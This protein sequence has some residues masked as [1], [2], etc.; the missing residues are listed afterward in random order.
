MTAPAMVVLS[1]M[2]RPVEPCVSA[3]ELD[4][5]EEITEFVEVVNIGFVGIFDTEPGEEA[6]GVAGLEEVGMNEEA[7]VEELVG[8]STTSI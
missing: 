4:V 8:K 5:G 6:V 1:P 2:L 7:D 3:G